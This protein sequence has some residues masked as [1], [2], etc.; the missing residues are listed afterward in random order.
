MVSVGSR[1]QRREGS[2]EA[3]SPHLQNG[4]GV[5]LLTGQEELCLFGENSVSVM[6]SLF[7]LVT[8][9]SKGG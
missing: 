5:S 2:D 9:E 6:L 8:K 3:Q 7:P 4:G 1:S